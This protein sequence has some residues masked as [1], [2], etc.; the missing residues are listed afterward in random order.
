MRE[1]FLAHGVTCP[2]SVLLRFL[3]PMTSDVSVFEMCGPEP[4]VVI[5]GDLLTCPHWTGL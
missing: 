4:S 1:M 2:E 3:F 5:I